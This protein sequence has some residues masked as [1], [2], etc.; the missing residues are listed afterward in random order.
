MLFEDSRTVTIFSK[1][2]HVFFFISGGGRDFGA[3]PRYK[4]YIFVA[5]P[6]FIG[7]L[8]SSSR[9]V[10]SQ[11]RATTYP[12]VFSQNRVTIFAFLRPPLYVFCYSGFSKVFANEKRRKKMRFL[13]KTT[14]NILQTI[15]LSLIRSSEVIELIRISNQGKIVTFLWV[16]SRI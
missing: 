4:F 13:Q 6:K 16:T 3:L 10:R 14:L 12:S 8:F 9:F 1:F 11:F 5:A 7:A 2:D 15:T